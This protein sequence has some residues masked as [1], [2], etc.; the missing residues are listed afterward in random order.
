M[1][2]NVLKYASAIGVGGATVHGSNLYFN[3]KEEKQKEHVEKIGQ[4]VS[5]V[6]NEHLNSYGHLKGIKKWDWNWDHRKPTEIDPANAN[7]DS[8]FIDVKAPG[9]HAYRNI[10]LIRHGQYDT[11]AKG[12]ENR[13]LTT[14]GHEQA[15][16]CGVRLAQFFAL[17]KE[18]AELKYKDKNPD[19][20]DFNFPKIK[21]Y[22][23]SMTRAQETAAEVMDIFKDAKCE[24]DFAGQ[25]DLLREGPPYPT[26]PPL[27]RWAPEASYWE[28]S[29]RIEAGFR[30]FIHRAEEDQ[31]EESHE[32][33]VCH[34]NVI[35][36]FVCRALQLPPEAWLRISLRHGSVTWIRI[37]PKGTVSLRSL[38]D[39]GFMPVDKCSR[40]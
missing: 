1:L 14:L 34:A 33:V 22:Q 26:E 9:K 7:A 31:K 35:R 6:T 10:F 4:I 29:A 17:E 40:R 23:S 30:K 8:E 19:S 38:G 24:Y 27:S 39:S 2:K 21:V 37:S 5:D 16:Y 11:D 32:V 3:E 13:K 15:R 28:E 36:Y 20:D 18:R 25:S 12:D